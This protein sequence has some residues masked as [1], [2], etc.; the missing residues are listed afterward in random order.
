[1][2]KKR[3]IMSE[4]KSNATGKIETD[5]TLMETA[6][7]GNAMYPFRFYEEKMSDFDFMTIDWHWHTE[8]EFIYIEAGTVS[9]NIGE[10]LFELTEGQGI[11]INSRILHELHSDNDAVIPNFLFLPTFIAPSDSLIYRKY[12][13]PVLESTTDYYVFSDSLKWQAH[14]LS[15][16]K[17]LIRTSR[18]DG[19]E[20]A[21]SV[22]IQEIWSLLSSN[23]VCVPK[24]N[25]MNSSS[26]ARLQK[27][28]QFVQQNYTEAISLNDIAEYGEVS[29]STTLNLFR[30]VLNTSPIN[31]L[32]SYR[33]KQATILLTKTEKKISAIALETGFS[34]T[35]YFCKT[36]KRMYSLT[37]TEYR[38][39]KN[40]LR[41]YS[42]P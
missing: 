16:M 42:R 40:L 21:V 24:D 19:N 33:L 2:L 37:P 17:E 35:D 38:N 26:L 39:S 29:I 8:L 5:D 10:D 25:S 11:F 34:N 23:I 13:L 7:H 6:L 15:V 41:S 32:I 12:V 28:M 1:M 30:K 4:N 20:L 22:L 9:I 3:I 31:Y 36:F 27:M 14:I 18:T